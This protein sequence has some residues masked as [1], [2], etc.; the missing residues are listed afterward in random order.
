MQLPVERRTRPSSVRGGAHSRCVIDG[1]AV[2]IST[3]SPTSSEA[4]RSTTASIT[5]SWWP[6]G[7]SMVCRTRQAAATPRRVDRAAARGPRAS[8]SG[9]D[10]VVLG[11]V[12][13]QRL[14]PRPTGSSPPRAAAR[15]GRRL[16]LQPDQPVEVVAGRPAPPGGTSRCAPSPRTPAPAPRSAAAAAAAR[17]GP[18]RADVLGVGE[19]LP[20]VEQRGVGLP[21]R[22]PQPLDELL[23]LRGPVRARARSAAASGR[24][25]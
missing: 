2:V 21:H 9:G 23:E 3:S 17:G 5:Q 8:A 15:S 19:R 18:R 16:P 25:R 7:S 1:A 20:L 12:L 13:L 6:S 11:V 10:R 24:R 14:R 4:S 22:L